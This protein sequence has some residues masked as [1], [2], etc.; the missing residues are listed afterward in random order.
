MGCDAALLW[1]VE[2]MQ[3]VSAEGERICVACVSVSVSFSFRQAHVREVQS[4]GRHQEEQL[5]GHPPLLQAET[6][7]CGAKHVARRPKW[8][9]QFYSS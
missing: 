2:Q 9:Q 6:C 3:T 7:N 1:T 4:S 8:N 5:Q